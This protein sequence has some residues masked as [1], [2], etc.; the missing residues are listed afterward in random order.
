MTVFY[1][2]VFIPLGLLI[3]LQIKDNIDA[4]KEEIEDEEESDEDD[5]EEE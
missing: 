3:F 1:V 5:S 4:K 2:V